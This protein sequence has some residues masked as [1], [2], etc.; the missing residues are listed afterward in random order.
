MRLASQVVLIA[1]AVG[2]GAGWWLYGDRV[3][4]SDPMRLLGLAP[5]KA[6]GPPRPPSGARIEVVTAP[7]RVAPLVERMESVGT[8]RAREAV[9]VTSRVSGIVAAIHFEEG[10]KVKA[11]D[12]LVELD[13]SAQVAAFDRA[14]AAADDA[15]T[16]LA[17]ARQ[18]RVTQSVPEAQIDQLEAALR[19]AEA[20]V[21]EAQARIEETRIIA[22]F[23]GR[24]GLRQVSLGALI[25]PGTAITTLDDLSRIRVEFAVPE[26]FVARLGLGQRVLATSPAFGARV[27]MGEVT[28]IDTRI[29][30]ATRAIRTVAEF[31]NADE[32]IRP[33][34]FLNI[35]LTLAE[36]PTA[37][38]VPE[39]AIDPVG[40][41]AYV[42]AVRQGRAIRQEVRVGTRL[43]GQVEIL[44]GLSPNEEVVVRG[45]QR[46]RN[47]VPVNVTETIHR[48][49]S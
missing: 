1:L 22:P 6:A 31:D 44:D 41:R 13:R 36:R 43:P 7:V 47:G 4:L 18:L 17:R 33:G 21:R 40:D 39:E 27:F 35:V 20:Q 25:Q 8:A 3:G 23:S 11:G 14:R 37:L 10:Q 9:T 34:L 2:A 5:P 38:L 29:D 16:R 46:L 32:T 45:L 49:L 48:P 28:A 15:R 30:P 12:V 26:V 19:Q 24:V 42:F